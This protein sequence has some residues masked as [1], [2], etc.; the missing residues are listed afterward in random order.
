[1]MARVWGQGRLGLRWGAAAA[2]LMLLAALAAAQP[3]SAGRGDRQPWAD[4][5]FAAPFAPVEALAPY[6]PGVVIAGF[7]AHVS[8]TRERALERRV[9][10]SSVEQLGPPIRPVREHGVLRIPL[11]PLLF[12]VPGADIS[13]TVA[14]LRA[15]RA[16]AYAEPDYL[17]SASA[18]PNDPS[19]AL[20]WGDSNTGQSVPTQTANEEEKLGPG[21]NGTPGA[22]DRAAKAWNVST[23]S[24]TVVIGEVDTGLQYTHPDLAANV[25]SNPTGVGKC[26]IG[27]HGYNV[28][29]K[30]CEP[31]DDDSVYGGHGT[32]VAGIMGAV[33]NNATGVAGMN[34]AT[35]LLPV[36]WLNSKGSGE[37]SGLIAALQWL[38]AAKQEGVNVRVVNDSATFKGTA[39]SQPLSEEIDLLG[40]ENILFVTAAG[41]TTENDDLEGSR[42]YPCDY[43]RPTELCVTA[44]N[45]TDQLP[46]WANWGPHTVQLGAPG[47]SI[48][49]TLRESKYGYLS[50]GSMA[51]AQVSGAAALVL[52]ARPG[53]SAEQVRSDIVENVDKIASLKEKVTTGGRL[54]VCKAMPGC[55]PPTNT[56]PPTITG[57]AQQERTLTEAHG[58][59][60]NEPLTGYAYQWLRCESSGGG[61]KEIPGATKQS[62]EAAFADVGH[63]LR[64]QESASNAG[65]TSAAATSEATAVVQANFATFGKSTAGSAAAGAVANRK[66]VSRYALSRAGYLL[67]LSIYL[68]PTHKR[69]RQPLAGVVYAD[70]AGSPGSLLGISQQLQITRASPSGWYDLVF[71]SPP[72]LAPG[73][74]WIGVLAGAP[75]KVA[76]YRYDRVAHA[77]EFNVNPFWTGASTPFGRPRS[78]AVQL[79]IF[80]TYTPS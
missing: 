34:W 24:R 49:S 68:Q 11:V 43:D 67:K 56:S 35:T 9:H 33:A 54:N 13:A 14:V 28:L 58:Q 76:G 1:M 25:W 69:G 2:A 70:A 20:Q 17:M 66:S 19:F 62:Y 15:E 73:N 23:G 79:S 8:L 29:T 3:A 50:G 65:G 45:N 61:C 40:L 72:A 36:K 5:I 26:P 21:V 63:T 46:T 59:W 27:A 38:I 47:E 44:T 16:I 22:D 53:M 51:S 18:T 55:M 37:T 42:R 64:V 77:G 39:F 57:T 6:R 31:M 52:S 74:Y 78:D 80:A 10:A 48:Y 41:N 7:H 4:N 30:T 71:A 60:T 75:S 12:Y 32:H